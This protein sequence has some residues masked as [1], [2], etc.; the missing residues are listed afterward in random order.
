MSNAID[1]KFWEYHENNPIVFSAF[2]MF[3]EE[4]K[5]RGYDHY[6]AKA[7][8]ERVRWHLQF[9]TDSDDGFKINNSYTSRYARLLVNEF[10]EFEGF[11]RTRVLKTASR[12]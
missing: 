6:S 11:F 8:F 3:A 1:V 5:N 9:E 4:V 2:K 12:L 10:P 7:I